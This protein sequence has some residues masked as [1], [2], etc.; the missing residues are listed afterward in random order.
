MRKRI[1]NPR[2]YRV[3]DCI[4]TNN[5]N[6]SAYGIESGPTGQTGAE[7]TYQEK[8]VIKEGK[9]VL[10]KDKRARNYMH[11]FEGTFGSDLGAGL[12]RK[13]KEK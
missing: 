8:N 5:K 3:H 2:K 13:Q 4:V 7:V 9:V 6:Y 11:V 10:V 12:F 1:D